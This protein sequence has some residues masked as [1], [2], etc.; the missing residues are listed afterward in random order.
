[1]LPGFSCCHVILE[2]TAIRHT[3][4]TSAFHYH[5]ILDSSHY[6]LGRLRLGSC[7]I[8]SNSS[9]SHGLWPAR[10]LCPWDFPGRNTGV[11][12]YALL[13][14]IFPTQGSKPHLMHRKWILYPLSH[15]ESRLLLKNPHTTYNL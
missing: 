14:G 11:G 2:C 12:C 13:Q 9:R 1:M 8:M 3:V 4:F 7:S 5:W 6:F 10:L 15:R